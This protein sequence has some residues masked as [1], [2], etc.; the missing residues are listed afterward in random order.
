MRFSSVVLIYNDLFQLL[1][2]YCSRR[3]KPS[4]VIDSPF[5][6]VQCNKTYV[7]IAPRPSPCPFYF[8]FCFICSDFGILIPR[9]K[10]SPAVTVKNELLSHC[11]AEGTR[12]KWKIISFWDRVFY[13]RAQT[14]VCKQDIIK[15]R[16]L[17]SPGLRLSRRIALESIWK[18]E[19][20][21]Y[22][23]LNGL[24]R[25]LGFILFCH[26]NKLTFCIGLHNF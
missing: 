14:L 8:L 20:G 1:S 17:V 11:P 12:Q 3:E 4:L 19:L 15:C 21:F 22:L 2:W 9:S 13:V 26:C 6:N 23:D 18:A 16:L 7:A 5:L 10:R 25:G 24:F